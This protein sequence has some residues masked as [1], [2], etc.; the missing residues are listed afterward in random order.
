MNIL[1]LSYGLAFASAFGAF[2]VS[3][4]CNQVTVAGVCTY[5][6]EEYSVGESF[7]AGDGCNTCTCEEGGGVAC[8]EMGCIEG[9]EHDGELVPIGQSVPAGDG[10]NTCTCGEGGFLACTTMACV[11]CLHEGQ[12]YPP[13]SSFP[14][15]DG[16]NTCTCD[17]MG[18]VGC[19][20]MACPSC[21]YLGQ[22]YSVGDEFPAGDGCNTCTCGAGGNVGCTKIACVCDPATEW[23]RE[24]VA[25]SP[26]ECAVIDYTCPP[27]TTP[28]A[29]DCGCG[30]EQSATCPE[31]FD[32]MPPSTCDIPQIEADCPYSTIVF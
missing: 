31:Y 14:A 13:G 25:L 18:N 20:E 5:G 24:Y 15:G 2:A 1:R 21:E 28:F 7:P 17:E 19:T 12:S 26:A 3:S 11:T 32:C 8:S 9:C 30:C 6:D 16:C 29:N 10:C 4:G 23:H 22:T 27:N